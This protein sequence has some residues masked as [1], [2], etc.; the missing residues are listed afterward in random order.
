MRL[1]GLLA[2]AA[3]LAVPVSAAQA[4]QRHRIDLPAGRLGDALVALGRQT[5][6]SIGVSDPALARRSVPSLRGAYTVKEAL[7]RLLRGQNARL[8]FI[9]AQ[10]ILVAAGPPPRKAPRARP[11]ARPK[12]APRPAPAAPTARPEESPEIVVTASKRATPRLSFPGTIH[13]VGGEALSR[14]GRAG[15]DALVGRLPSLAS[16]HFGPGRNKLFIRGVADSSFNGPTQ[17]TAGQYLG[18]MRLN[19]NAPDPDLRLYDLDRVE[20]LAGPQG[21]LYGAGSLG[22]IIRAVPAAPRLDAVESAAMV[23][24]SYTQHGKP[25]AD[26]AGLL[27]LPLAKDRIGLRLVAYG[28]EQGGYIDDLRRGLS[29]VNR[30]RIAGGRAALRARP[31][32]GWTADLG[33]TGQRIRGRDA[34][35]ADGDGPPLTRGSAA[36]QGF[37]NDY[38]LGSLTLTKEWGDL[39]SVTAAGVAR[40]S[41][42]ERFDA[43]GAD[44]APT[45]FDQANRATLLSLESR[46]TR[47]RPDGIGW[48]L[49]FSALRNRAEQ[50]LSTEAFGERTVLPGVENAVTEGTLFGEGTVRLARGITAT[51]GGRVAYSRLYGAALDFA[52]GPAAQKLEGRRSATAF[53]PSGALAAKA[54]P[55][56]LFFL[57]YQE[58]FRPGGLALVRG[59]D[60]RPVGDILWQFRDDDVAAVEAGVRYGLPGAGRI[61][62]AL[63][64][65][66][67]GW[68][69]IQADVIDTNGRQTTANI[70]DGRIY[71]LDLSLGW[72]PLSALSVELAAVLNDS[73]ITKAGDAVILGGPVAVPGKAPLPNVARVNGRLA[74]DY[75]TS[76]PRRFDLTFSAA[77]R[78]TG[79]SILGIGGFLE[80][81]QGDWLDLSLGVRAEGARHAFTLDLTNL[82]DSVG[83]RFAVGSPYRL[84]QQRQITPLRPRTLRAGW[85]ARF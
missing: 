21:T 40:Q 9:D 30:A 13:V 17:A 22:G 23:G 36:A 26:A 58:G 54:A 20:V 19:Y 49:G 43:T 83:N 62:A 44:V 18:E 64:L 78:Y 45:I 65:A 16:T 50:R 74:A 5:G 79:K 3:V 8:L 67:T 29:D 46:L 4:A 66:R 15:S 34:Q 42:H 85:E 38:L 61:D 84:V 11:P 48:L 77:A 35:Y 7:N 76:I 24:A 31:G 52:P 60:G 82:L 53:L 71:T 73:S 25:G 10:T 72:R 59:F 27:N 57:R 6:I 51:A 32:S 68:R 2:A 14:E 39:R 33:L 37:R 41:L 55:D 47:Q 80:E 1:A 12:P 56:L 70:G 63:S 75:R 28:L 81:K 69:D